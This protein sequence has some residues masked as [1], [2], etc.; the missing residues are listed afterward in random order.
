MKKHDVN[1]IMGDFN[2]MV[3]KVGI[4][5]VPG[6]H[7]LGY[8]IERS[9]KLLEFRQ[10]HSFIITNTYIKK[11]QDTYILGYPLKTPSDILFVTKLI[12]S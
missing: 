3:G 1:I 9:D 7:G 8:R 4:L 12:L 11:I 10:K 6:E 2:V 5:G